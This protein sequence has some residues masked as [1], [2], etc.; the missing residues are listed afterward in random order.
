MALTDKEKELYRYLRNWIIHTNEVPSYSKL[1][2]LLGYKSKRSI[3][4]LYASLIEKGYVKRTGESIQLLKQP[5]A[6]SYKAETIDL[7]IVGNITC[8]QLNLAS[9]DIQN[10]ISV[11]TMLAKP[12]YKYFILR[13]TGDSMNKKNISEG[14]LILIRQQETAKN[15]D[16]VVA[17]VND[18]ATLKEFRRVENFIILQPHSTNPSHKP[19]LLTSDFRIQGVLVAVLPE[20]VS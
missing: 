16:V 19:I 20:I 4:L 17:L 5:D 3:S 1:T 10:V 15:G 12:P 2:G 18:Q 8:G 14:S 6:D 9:Q 11:S 7:P 13:A